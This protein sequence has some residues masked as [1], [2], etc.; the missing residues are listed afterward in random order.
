LITQDYLKSILNYEEASGIFTWKVSKA[1]NIKIGSVAGIHD[2]CGYWIIRIDKKNYRAHRLAWLYMNGNFPNKYIDHI[3]NNKI[4]NIYRNLREA[5]DVEN[6]RNKGL[7]LNNST[8][9]KGVSFCNLNKK[10]KAQARFNGKTKT[11]GY[12]KS[13]LDASNKYI[14]FVKELHGDFYHETTSLQV[15]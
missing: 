4:N 3:D 15:S 1:K 14:N 6:G 12:F 7:Q 13:A 11:L 2:K 10:F 9:Y 8:G 5:N